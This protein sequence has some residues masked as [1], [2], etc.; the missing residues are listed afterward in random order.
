MD[1]IIN[2][3]NNKL[4]SVYIHTSP[5]GKRY[6]GITSMQP[7]EKR[8]LNGYG[9]KHNYHFTNAI[10]CYGW[11]NFSHEIV[12]TNLSENEAI[13]MEK[14]LIEKYNTMN[15]NYGYNQ[16]SG[17]EIDKE[18]TE[19]VKQKIREAAIKNCS[20]LERKQKLS[21]QAKK[22]WEDEEYKEKMRQKAKKQWE[23]EE[24]RN[25]MTEKRQAATGEKNPFYGKHHTEETKEI[26]RQK[27]VGKAISEEARKKMSIS[28]SKRWQNEEYRQF[29]TSM[30]QGENNPHYGKQHTEEVKNR[31]GE[32]NGIS[33]VQLDLQNNFIAEYRSAKMAENITGINRTSIRRCC[34]DQQKTAGGYQ[35]K[36]KKKWQLSLITIPN[37]CEE[38]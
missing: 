2:N 30:V 10:N 24:Y 13:Q 27:N 16:T 37:E 17:G 8:W 36:D 6:I 22:Q 14:D 3:V 29:I 38:K 12:A 31:I 32:L 4:Y 7:P 34:N 5:N 1:D 9:Y 19:E 23:D 21:E 35:W 20:T 25:S 33:I 15:S 11:N 28:S 26:L 18:Y